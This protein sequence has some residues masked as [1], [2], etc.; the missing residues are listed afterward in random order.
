MTR[1]EMVFGVTRYTA[2]RPVM[3]RA[4]A[5]VAL[6]ALSAG[7][8]TRVVCGWTCAHVDQTAATDSCHSESGAEPAFSV[9]ANHCD[10]PAVPA[11]VFT[12]SAEDKA[13]V[14]LTP[15]DSI[16]VAPPVAS[17][18]SF[19]LQVATAGPPAVSD[20]LVPLRI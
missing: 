5:I 11:L 8:V 4:L 16:V 17:L 18:Q 13:F 7:S 12:K 20:R 10:A 14:A 2:R 6:L 1:A 15:I 9:G 3:Q 19:D